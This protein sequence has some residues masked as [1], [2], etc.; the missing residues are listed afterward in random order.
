MPAYSP[1]PE[2]SYE[3]ELVEAPPESV[4]ETPAEPMEAMPE[5]EAVEAPPE[6]EVP[7][8]EECD[9]ATFFME[10]SLFDEASEILETV[11]IAYP[12][13]ARATELMARLESLRA[14]GG[15]PDATSNGE[16]ESSSGEHTNG[17]SQNGERDAFDLAAE[18]A[19]ELGDVDSGADM[20]SGEVP[21]ADYQVSVDEVFSEFKKGLEKVV[22]PEDVD[23]HYD[24]GI[25]Y[26]EMGLTDDA[27]GEFNVALQGCLGKK[28]EVDCLSMIAALQTMKG[29]FGAAVDAL[30]QALTTEHAAGDTEKAIRYELG[31]ALEQA[32]EA[33]KALGQFLKVQALD[34]GYRD[35]AAAVERLGAQVTPEDDDA[36][37]PP[38]N[39]SKGGGKPGAARKVGYL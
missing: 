19:N 33:G 38:R 35:V 6:E 26:K 36:P 7:A 27:I 32:G 3:E 39:G 24:L 28:K 8:Q 37:P 2:Q 34:G 12:G 9:E 23:T 1:P 22:K 4:E 29:D 30:K 13:H 20:P 31:G 11:L 14:G 17:A 18:L 10:Q 25:A 16:A 5:E 15:A 21:S